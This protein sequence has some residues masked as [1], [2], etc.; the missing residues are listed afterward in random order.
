MSTRKQADEI[1]RFV[2]KVQSYDG[3]KTNLGTK[4]ISLPRLTVQVTGDLAKSLEKAL[5]LREV[6]EIAASELDSAL[7]QAIQSSSWATGEDIVDSGELLNS[8][9][10][11]VSGE[12][13]NIEYDVDYAA[14]VH[15]GGYITPYGNENAKKVFIPARPWVQAVLDGEITGNGI[16]DIYQKALEIVLSR[17]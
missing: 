11:S 17:F 8:Q 13:I 12:T 2:K 1:L 7:R 10:V 9:K 6:A 16:V 5:D 15:Y 14:L 3:R 4:G